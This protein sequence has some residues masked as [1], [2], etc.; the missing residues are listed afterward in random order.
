M[1]RRHLKHDMVVT[2]LLLRSFVKARCCKPHSQNTGVICSNKQP[3]VQHHPAVSSNDEKTNP[4]SSVDNFYLLFSASSSKHDNDNV[5][6][7]PNICSAFAD[8][9]AFQFFH[10]TVYFHSHASSNAPLVTIALHNC[11]SMPL[12]AFPEQKI[13]YKFGFVIAFIMHSLTHIN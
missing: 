7:L 11:G 9:F 13:I 2:R 12:N 3:L 6:L 8:R 5:L 1:T 10:Y 4:T